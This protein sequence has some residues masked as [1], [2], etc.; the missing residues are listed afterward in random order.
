VNPG[1]RYLVA[2]AVFGVVLGTVYYLLTEEWIGSILLWT[3]GLMPAIVLVWS[4][5]RGMF[6]ARRPE[7]DP[8]ADPSAFADE[9]LGTFPAASAWP[10]F[11]VL[12]AVALGASIVYGLILLPV[13]LGLLGWSVLGFMR[14]SQD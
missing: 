10:L 7:D 8:E 6:R 14:E 3:M 11:L 1:A 4:A 12:A 9:E 2:Y 5:R 13:G